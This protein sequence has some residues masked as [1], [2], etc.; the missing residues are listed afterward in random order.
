[1]VT[2]STTMI[3]VSLFVGPTF[4]QQTG[5]L[6]GPVAGKS[7]LLRAGKT[8]GRPQITADLLFFVLLLIRSAEFYQAFPSFIYLFLDVLHQL[9]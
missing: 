7:F 4:F 9:I 5:L 2:R 8:A 3:M 1:M 6:M